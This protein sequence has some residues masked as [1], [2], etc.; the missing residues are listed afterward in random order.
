MEVSQMEQKVCPKCHEQGDKVNFKT[1]NSLVIGNLTASDYYHICNN[2]NCEIVYF[3]HDLSIMYNKN[4]ISVKVWFK[5][6]NDDDVSVCYC[7][8]LTRKDIQRAV[9]NGKITIPEIRDYT[10]KKDTGRCLTEN[11]T[12]KCCHRAIMDEV[13]KLIN[14][15]HM[16]TNCCK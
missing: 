9:A 14:H 1:V 2:A 7:A 3:N 8:Q 15:E 16:N 4:D 12:G 5:E 13:N 11:P 10:N 6:L